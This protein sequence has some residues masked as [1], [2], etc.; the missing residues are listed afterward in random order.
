MICAGRITDSMPVFQAGGSGASPTPALHFYCD[1]KDARQ[2]VCQHHYSG[3]CPPSKFYFSAKVN[4]QRVGVCV[5]NIPQLPKIAK[6]YGVDLE[7][8]RLVLL[9]DCPKNSESRFIGWALR[10][11]RKNTQYKKVISYADPRFGHRGTIYRASN[12]EYLGLE[13]GSGTRRIFVDGVEYHSKTAFGKWGCSGAGLK[14]ILPKSEVRVEVM[15]KKHVYT[16]SL[17]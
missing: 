11:L 12:F 3:K 13:R 9:D 14:K 10:W 15:P 17:Q 1:N 5:F 8:N 2:F 6:C 7:L 16:F 4:N